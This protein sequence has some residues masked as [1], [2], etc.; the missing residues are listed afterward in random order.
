MDNDSKLIIL[1]SLNYF[2]ARFYTQLTKIEEKSGKDSIA[3][4][5]LLERYQRYENCKRSFINI[6]KLQG[7]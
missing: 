7:A 2:L 5:R 1:E 4:K 6:Q 3:Y